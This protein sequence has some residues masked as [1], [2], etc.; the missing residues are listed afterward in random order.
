MDEIL[1]KACDLFI[2]RA[3]EV[4]CVVNVV[5]LSYLYLFPDAPLNLSPIKN[6]LLAVNAYGCGTVLFELVVKPR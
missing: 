1:R 2:G 4:T 5:S 6:Y 3:L